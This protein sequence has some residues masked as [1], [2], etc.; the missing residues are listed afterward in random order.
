ML[1]IGLTGGVASGKS[2]V[3]SRFKKFKIP[4][5][6]ADLEVHKLFLADKEIFLQVKKIFPSAIVNGKIDRGQLGAEVLQD[7]QKLQNLEDIIYPKL[8]DRENLFLK[9]C[10]RNHH[11]IV[12]LNIPLLFEKGG[13]KR[14]HKTIA[15]IV[16]PQ[17][18]FHRFRCRSKLEDKR[19]IEEKF[20][21]ITQ[22]QINNLQRKNR[23]DFLIHNG[24]G[25]AF[26]YHQVQLV[27]KKC[28]QY[29]VSQPI[30]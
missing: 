1:I 5:F 7:R 30:Q 20:K 14:C 19:L 10:R 26:C 12:V 16:S 25:K 18:Q 4:V 6:D 15:I 2:F 22:H 11:K 29:V 13:Y 21:N 24:L 27:A 17:I 23:A 8:R 9:N 3:A 28:L